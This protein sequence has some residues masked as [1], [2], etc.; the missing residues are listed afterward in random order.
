MLTFRTEKN[1]NSE[2]RAYKIEKGIKEKSLTFY[3]FVCAFKRQT[4]ILNEL[5]I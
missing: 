2:K 5:N 1:L 4:F 3:K